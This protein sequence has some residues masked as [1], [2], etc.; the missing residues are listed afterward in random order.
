[1]PANLKVK[2]AMLVPRVSEKA[3]LGADKENVYV[4]NVPTEATKSQIAGAVK[5]AYKVTPTKV[6]TAKVAAKTVFRA[7]KKGEKSGGKK[8]YVYLKKDD[9]I[10]II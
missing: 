9:K 1:M 3:L 6:R 5:A 2:H 7:G 8:T 4:F 10:E